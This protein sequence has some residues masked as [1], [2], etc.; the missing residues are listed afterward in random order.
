MKIKKEKKV[1]TNIKKAFKQNATKSRLRINAG[2]TKEEKDKFKIEAIINKFSMKELMDKNIKIILEKENYKFKTKKI[3]QTTIDSSF[4]INEDL[5]QD[6]KEY[7]KK[8]NDNNHRQNIY[9]N[10]MTARLFIY[11]AILLSITK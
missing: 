6:I 8:Y 5:M 7:V 3:E 4:E 1:D 10:K 11:N 9:D 2:A